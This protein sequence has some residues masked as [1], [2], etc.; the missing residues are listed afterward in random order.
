MHLQ[1][2]GARECLDAITALVWLF[3]IVA[4]H[5]Y[6]QVIVARETVTTNATEEVT[7]SRVCL[8]VAAQLLAFLEG[9][10]A[11][12]AGVQELCVE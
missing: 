8:F 2:G 12:L 1:I 4:S 11:T 9:F 6:T 7:L 10:V 5:M 3:A